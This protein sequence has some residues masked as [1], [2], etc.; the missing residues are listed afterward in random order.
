MRNSGILCVYINEQSNGR[1][2]SWYF[3]GTISELIYW[4]EDLPFMQYGLALLT[5]PKEIIQRHRLGDIE[6]RSRHCG[7]NLILFVNDEEDSF[8]R[9]YEKEFPWQSPRE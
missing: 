5:H 6:L 7:G 9:V 1:W 8:L 4:W 3:K 2:W